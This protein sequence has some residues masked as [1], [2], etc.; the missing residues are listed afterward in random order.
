MLM[1]SA[2]EAGAAAIAIRSPLFHRFHGIEA[3][4]D[5]MYACEPCRS[6]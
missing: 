1:P 5:A 6:R 3:Q 2:C 4:L